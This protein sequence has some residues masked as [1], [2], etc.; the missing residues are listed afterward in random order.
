M[1]E[2]QRADPGLDQVRQHAMS[3]AEV[4]DV[5]GGF[6]VRNDVPMRKWRNPRSSASDDWSVV[7]QV[8][9]PHGYRSEV[10]QLVHMWVSGRQ[11]PR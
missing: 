8:V 7:H 5:P 2:K 10:L 1:V 3:E 11:G 4:D 9:L 6:Y